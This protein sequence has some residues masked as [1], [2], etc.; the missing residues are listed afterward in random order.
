MSEHKTNGK[1]AMKIVQTKAMGAMPGT[2]ADEPLT[3]FS[4][5]ASQAS[6]DDTDKHGAVADTEPAP[7]PP[8][9]DELRKLAFDADNPGLRQKLADVAEDMIAKANAPGGSDVGV[10]CTIGVVPVIEFRVGKTSML[11]TPD[12]ADEL[13]VKFAEKAHEIRAGGDNVVRFGEAALTVDIA[14]CEG[15]AKD[16]RIL[17]IEVRNGGR[18]G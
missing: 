14:M 12:K 10:Q 7:A 4:G 18:M 9:P 15:L 17:S 13:S 11:L 2:V 16:L 5:L 8:S 6:P 1:S 3:D